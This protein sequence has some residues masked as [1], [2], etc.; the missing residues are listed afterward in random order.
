MEG[1]TLSVRE[2]MSPGLSWTLGCAGWSWTPSPGEGKVLELEQLDSD[3]VSFIAQPRD[4][5]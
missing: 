1:W 2:E 5:R 3:P 4:L